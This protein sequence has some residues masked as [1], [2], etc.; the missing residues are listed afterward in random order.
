M[1]A[2]LIGIS[3]EA[4]RDRAAT[5]LLGSDFQTQSVPLHTVPATVR[6]VAIGN[7]RLDALV[8]PI[9]HFTAGEPPGIG[10]AREIRALEDGISFRGAVRARTTPIVFLAE[11]S[12]RVLE[13]APGFPM[14]LAAPPELADIPWSTYLDVLTTGSTE[15]IEAVMHVVTSW[16]EA[17]VRELDYV[18]YVVTLDEAGLV[19]VGHA[20]Q[21]KRRESELLADEATP[22]ALRAAQYLILTEDFLE[23]FNTY[24]ELKFLIE[25]YENIARAER[26]KPESVFQRFFE[27]NPHLILRDAFDRYWAKPTLRIPESGGRCYQPDFVLRPRAAANLGTKWEVLDLKLPDD[28]LLTAGSFHPAFSQKLTKAIQQLRDYRMYFNRPDAKDE[29]FARFGYQPTHPRISVLI[30]RNDRTS[31][32]EHAQG[33]AALDVNVITYDEILELEERRVVL[34]GHFAGIFSS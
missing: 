32:L 5:N 17:L 23:T 13:T 2:I 26:I 14:A 18:G 19:K 33:S 7:G 16:R 6:A 4:E 1:L 27:K 29:L 30:G 15:L 20:L 21:R 3:P 12:V 25:H 22:G 9:D 28:P 8:L 10:I 34:Q 24:D 31:G 11:R